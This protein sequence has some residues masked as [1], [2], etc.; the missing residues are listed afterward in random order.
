[1]KQ[2]SVLNWAQKIAII[3]IFNMFLSQFLKYLPILVIISII[4][5]GIFCDT[6]SYRL[7]L[8]IQNGLKTCM[9]TM[10]LELRNTL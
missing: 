7:I 2:K 8:L 3:S 4:E 10:A 9:L 5:N 1:M 6:C